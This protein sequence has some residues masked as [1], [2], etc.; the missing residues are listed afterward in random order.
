MLQITNLSVSVD[1]K[2]ILKNFS[3]EV[4]SGEIHAIMGPNG[5]GKSTLASV[6]A[7]KSGYTITSGS[8]VFQGKNLLEL[9]PEIRAREGLFLA[10]QH[11][12]EI[13][14]V[15]NLQFLKTACN[16]IRRYRGQETL[17]AMDFELLL[18]ET[19]QKMGMK[20]EFIHR[21]F[22]EGFSGGEKKRNEILQM[23]LLEP[24]LMLLDE[25]DSG[26]D[27]DALR[28]VADGIKSIHTKN[29]A[30]IMITHYKRLLEYVTP[31]YIHV[32]VDGQI[33]KTGGMEIAQ[34]L[35]EKGY[36]ENI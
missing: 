4:R 11:P 27:I 17:D 1:N 31:A 18:K 26:L 16:E 36:S 34:E 7:G 13:P 2:N 23:A 10:F 28:A 30:V 9:S 15:T 22:N 35:E 3:L 21:S 6:L 12:V 33:V 25:I 8:V 19:M 29:N 20:S 14:G 5:T 32:M 24:K